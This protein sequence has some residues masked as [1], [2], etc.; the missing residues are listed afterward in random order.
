VAVLCALSLSIAGQAAAQALPSGWAATDIGAVGAAGNS[1]ESGGTFTTAGGGA[2]I[3]GTADAFRFTY[4]TMTGD[5]SIVARVA[6]VE[7]V[8]AWTKAGVE[9]R[10]TLTA[11]SQHGM[12]LVSPGKGTAYQRRATSN[13]TSTNTAGPTTTAP[14]W[15]KLTRVA[16]VVTAYASVDGAT[17]TKVASQTI[18]M[19]STIYVGLGIGSHVQGQ[20]AT[21]VFDNV[22]VTRSAPPPPTSCA[23]RPRWSTSSRAG[24]R[25]VRTTPTGGGSSR[26]RSPRCG[27]TARRCR[28]LRARWRWRPTT[29]RCWP[30]TARRSRW[31]QTAR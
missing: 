11:G 30:T 7:N 14:Y 6:S 29:G 19:P 17:W 10:A 24:C 25:T 15:V 4:T 12:M 31:R 26:A 27:A 1:S 22:T 8:A 23:R 20:L 16:N 18:T 13:G 28:P 3:W 9:M 21:A 2:D 5:G